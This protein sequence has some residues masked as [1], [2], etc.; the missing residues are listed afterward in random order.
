MADHPRPSLS[1]SVD[2]VETY[3]ATE[4]S[5]ANRIVLMPVDGSEHSERAFTWY[6]ENV[7]RPGDGLCLVHIVEPMSPGV[8]YGIASKSPA[9]K[10]E[11]SRQINKLLET[12]K[13]L[14]TKFITRCESLEV[15]ARFTIHMGTKP[16]E[17]IVRLAQEHGAHMIVVGNRGI[18][19]VRRTFLG[20]VSDYI[21]H[22]A[23]VPVVIVPPPKTSKKK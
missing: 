18:G 11:F 2:S 12:G 4:L 1:Q 15:P 17:H 3:G 19:T 22:N 6:L 8:N 14:R 21:L 10:E 20:S 16:G 5:E 23:N 13:L 9:L 7:L